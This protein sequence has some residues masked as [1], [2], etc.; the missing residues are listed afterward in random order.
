MQ[1]FR[2]SD[3]ENLRVLGR[4]NGGLDPLT[5]FWNASGIELNVKGSEC[6]VDLHADYDTFEPWIDILVNN[7]RTQRL[8]LPKGD[9]RLC[10]FRGL[11]P[12]LVRNVKILRDTQPMQDDAGMLFQITGFETDG[13]LEPL[14]NYAMKIEF[15]GDSITTGEGMCGA[16]MDMDWTGQNMDCVNNYT[17]LTARALNAEYHVF[18]QSGWGVHCSW[19]N[20]IHHTIAGYYETLCGFLD[21]EAYSRYGAGERWSFA[22]WQPDVIVVNLGAN[23]QFAFTSPAWTDPETGRKYKLRRN[24]YGLFEPEDRKIFEKDAVR[25]LR[26]LRRD[27][28]NAYI[29]WAYGMLGGFGGGNSL[30]PEISDAVLRCQTEDGDGRVE[31]IELPDTAPGEYGSRMH[32]GIPSHTHAAEVLARRI[33]EIMQG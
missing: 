6:W 8:M 11:N 23:D 4:T 15:I 24:A 12:S 30:Y 18:S 3:I 16:Y 21:P 25:L 19:D 33:Q 7:Y 32:P 27:N 26:M 20:N 14:R 9:T 5:L 22:S 29:L 1:K 31:S 13:S 28:P 10:V 2:L 17:F